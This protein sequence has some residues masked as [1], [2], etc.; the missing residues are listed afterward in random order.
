M[1]QKSLFKIAMM[2]ILITLTID[3]MAFTMLMTVKVIKYKPAS[4]SLIEIY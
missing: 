2:D 3:M 1:I 4:Y